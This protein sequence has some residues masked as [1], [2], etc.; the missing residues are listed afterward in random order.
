MTGTPWQVD[1]GETDRF[2]RVGDAVV[3]E[4]ESLD[5][6]GRIGVTMNGKGSGSSRAAPSSASPQPASPGSWAGTA[7]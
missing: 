3:V 7:P 5:A 4:V 1:V 6:T 2:L